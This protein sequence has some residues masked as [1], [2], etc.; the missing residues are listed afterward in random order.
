M[1]VKTGAAVTVEFTTCHPTTGA[2]TNG[3]TLP[4]GILYVD[5]V[6]NG[7]A[8]TVTNITA[9][10]YKAAVTLPALTAGQ[11]VGIRITTA[12]ATAPGTAV[13]WQD[14][15][16]TVYVS[17]IGTLVQAGVPQASIA[18]GSTLTTG[19]LIGGTYADTYLDNGLYLT[20]APVG[21]P[22][23][24]FTLNRELDFSI[25]S[26]SPYN[27]TMNGRFTAG[28]ARQAL[29]H[30]WNWGTSGWDALSALT[31]TNASTDASY[32]AAI[33]A[34]HVQTGTGAVKLRFTSTSTT[35]TDRLYLDQVLVNAVAASAS[36]AQIAEATHLRMAPYAAY[37]GGVWID[38]DAGTAGT[39]VGT[40][41][42]ATNPCLTLADA[43]TI[44]ASLGLKRLYFKPD[45]TVTLTHEGNFD[46]WRF[47]GKGLIHLN[48]ASIN[49][50]VFDDCELVD[51]VATGEDAD[52]HECNIG[53]VTLGSCIMRNCLLTG[54][55]TTVA[56]GLYTLIGCSDGLPG[57]GN[58]PDVVVAHDVGFAARYWSGGIEL[59]GVTLG[60]FVAIGGLG[61][62]VINA[63]CTGGQ[64]V[65]RGNV[66]LTDIGG[67]YGT[68]DAL[69]DGTLV[70]SARFDVAQIAEHSAD[71]T[72]DLSPILSAIAALPDDTDVAALDA[73]LDSIIL[74]TNTIGAL[75]VTVTSPVAADG[76][77]TIYPGDDYLAAHGRGLS[78]LIADP[79]HAMVLDAVGTV[80][81]LKT[82]QTSW[83]ATSATSTTAGY[84][85]L[86]EATAA[87]TA[88]L[89]AE[90]QSYVIEAEFADHHVITLASGSLV[91]AT[92]L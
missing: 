85:V 54:T 73:L 87:Q 48:D 51:G 57:T 34:A 14:T 38:T 75:T 89:T 35:T 7:A 66:D 20:T 71:L 45:S 5:G 80:V 53:S 4:T 84:T 10:V 58:N 13:V 30:I 78:V 31:L 25:G 70:D 65:I 62:V 8:V 21:T 76:T 37:Q 46:Y 43:L 9:G 79:T 68:F 90:S 22:V 47:V 82:A 81:T 52:F 72:A 40:H 18:V 27:V 56:N 60:C 55:F 29:V 11:M 1:S 44:A 24:G 88:L 74:K 23:G 86:I 64:I 26:A 59:K 91:A 92:D 28:A 39:T 17:D 67:V 50:A 19:T 3:D 2:P 83:P 16:D 12:V 42:L 32:S 33:L 36:A 6:A 15:A 63:S 77:I 49:D 69:A 41:G 61:R